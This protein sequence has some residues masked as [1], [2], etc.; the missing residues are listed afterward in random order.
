[1][2]AD[3]THYVQW[4]IAAMIPGLQHAVEALQGLLDECRAELS[5]L[6]QAAHEE[7]AP[8]RQRIAVPKS[9][10]P[11]E[12]ARRNW[13]TGMSKAAVRA[14][15]KRR[16][17]MRYSKVKPKKAKPTVKLKPDMGTNKYGKVVT[18]S[19]WGKLTAE[20][21]KAEMQRRMAVRKQKAAAKAVAA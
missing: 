20:E 3:K 8:V 1:M 9:T 5:G 2:K 17:L 16:S 19:F 18:D 13:T 21:R 15:M 11:A 12:K 7:E 4:G 6:Q 14:E 10:R